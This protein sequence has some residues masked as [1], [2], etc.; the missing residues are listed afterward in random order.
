MIVI[1]SISSRYI[2]HKIYRANDY[3]SEYNRLLILFHKLY[4]VLYSIPFPLVFKFYN[5]SDGTPQKSHLLIVN[6]SCG[7]QKSCGE[8]VLWVIYLIETFHS[9][10]S[11]TKE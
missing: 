2:L 1:T 11:Y 9:L 7:E 3:Q 5:L 6:K 8:K 10:F 4:C